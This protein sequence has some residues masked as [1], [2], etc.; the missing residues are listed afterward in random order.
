MSTLNVGK[1][2]RWA[3]GLNVQEWEE[4]LSAEMQLL[5][6]VQALIH[7]PWR[8]FGRWTLFT[9]KAVLGAMRGSYQSLGYLE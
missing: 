6:K 7:L 3:V 1:A 4:S 9:A 2:L 8:Q 5:I